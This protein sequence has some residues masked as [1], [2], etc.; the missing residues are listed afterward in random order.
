MTDYD[1][2]FALARFSGNKPPRQSRTVRGREA[3]LFERNFVGGRCDG[4]SRPLRANRHPGDFRPGAD[5]ETKYQ[6]GIRGQT[7]LS[8]PPAGISIRFCGKFLVP[9]YQIGFSI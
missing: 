9:D 5:P 1:D 4:Q 3:D 8:R 2:A 6:Q 7:P